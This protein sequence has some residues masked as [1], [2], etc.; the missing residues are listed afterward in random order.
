MENFD[1]KKYLSEGKLLQEEAINELDIKKSIR[2]ILAAGMIAAAS[3]S[4]QGQTKSPKT[5]QDYEKSIDSL[6]LI[7][8]TTPEEIQLKRTALQKLVKEKNTLRLA[9]VTAA[10]EKR[11]QDY[12]DANPGST[13]EDYFKDVE[14][15]QSGPDCSLPG[16]GGG[17][18]AGSKDCKAGKGDSTKRIR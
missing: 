2:N 14:K 1:L 6:K 8:P 10:Q 4:A 13:R 16:L 7:K 11:I 5:V 18:T 15:R 12:I 3:L 9:P 17:T